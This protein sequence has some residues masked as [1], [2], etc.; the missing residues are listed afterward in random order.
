MNGSSSTT[1]ATATSTSGSRT[2]SR[3]TRPSAIR[4]CR[5]STPTRGPSPCG[6]AVA[7]LPQRRPRSGGRQRPLHRRHEG[8]RPRG[9]RREDDGRGRLRL[10]RRRRPRRLHRARL[11]GQRALA[12]RRRE[13][14]R[15]RSMPGSRSDGSGNP[16]ASMHGTVGDC[17]G[18]G[19]FDLFVPNLAEGCLY[20]Q[21]D[22]SRRP[23]LSRGSLFVRGGRAARSRG[24]ASR[25]AA[26]GACS[27]PTSTSTATTTCWWCSAARST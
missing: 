7:A 3:S 10:R 5:R 26:R 8:G 24:D 14:R 12:Q 6:P 9:S 19:A 13:V 11:D 17:D 16:M 1:T 20:R 25:A 23:A 22:G 21:R 18:D 4:A 27:S 15:S 2:T